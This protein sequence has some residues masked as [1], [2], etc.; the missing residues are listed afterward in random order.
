MFKWSFAI[1]DNSGKKQ[2]FTIRA[3][4]KEEAIKKGFEKARKNA[5]GDLSYSWDCRLIKN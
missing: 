1:G 2:F 3:N 4:S 5:K